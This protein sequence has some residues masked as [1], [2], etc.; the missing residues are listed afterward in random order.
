MAS[1]SGD[2]TVRLSDAKTHEQIA[3]LQGHE[4]WASSGTFSPDGRWLASASEDSAIPIWNVAT[5]ELVTKFTEDP[6]SGTQF[7]D[8]Q[9]VGWP[10]RSTQ[11]TG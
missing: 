8:T 7:W 1:A 2:E 6:E 4:G 3:E 5:K 10:E 11:R 9:S